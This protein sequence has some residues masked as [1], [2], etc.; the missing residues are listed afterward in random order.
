M[1]E[2][3]KVLLHGDA[4]VKDPDDLDGLELGMFDGGAEEA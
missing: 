3:G 1:T 2:E 4:F